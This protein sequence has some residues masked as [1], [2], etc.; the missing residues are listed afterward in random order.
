MVDQG[1]IFFSSKM[2]GSKELLKEVTFTIIFTCKVVELRIGKDIFQT[3]VI[4][5]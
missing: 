2:D 4:S 1:G 5:C 3:A